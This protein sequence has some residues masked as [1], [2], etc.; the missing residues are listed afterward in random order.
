MPRSTMIADSAD[1]PPAV[2]VGAHDD[3]VEVGALVV[4]PADV[5]R[6]V[7]APVDHVVVA[8]EGRGDAHARAAARGRVE[9]RR[10]TRRAGRLAGGVPDDELAGG[11]GGRRPDEAPLLLLGAVVPDGHQAEAVDEDGGGEAR[12]DRADLLGRDHEVDV[13]QPAAA[14][15]LGQ[16]RERDAALH[17]LHVGGLGE[18]EPGQRVRLG[19]G[20]A[21]DGREDVLR[22][23]AGGLLQVLLVLRQSEIDRHAGNSP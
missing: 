15:L 22:E 1:V 3:Q 17:R 10:A 13:G 23:L 11:V 9:V 7:L 19:V 18:V 21:H 4:P 8:V 14:V 6:P 12:V 5:A 16:H 20:L 2:R